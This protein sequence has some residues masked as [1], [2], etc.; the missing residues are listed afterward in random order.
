MVGLY[1]RIEFD[2]RFFSR[3]DH[4][5][6]GVNRYSAAPYGFDQLGIGLD[7]VAVRGVRLPL[8][9]TCVTCTKLDRFAA[10]LELLHDA[11]GHRFGGFAA[12]SIDRN[13]CPNLPYRLQR[14]VS[15]AADADS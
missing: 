7:G 12:V 13:L 9:T 1:L 10:F 5:S 4:R 6:P 14:R 2:L 15:T 3:R 8:V 11:I